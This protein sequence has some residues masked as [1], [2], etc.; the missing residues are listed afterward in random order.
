[1]RAILPLLLLLL[2]P[3]LSR[4][5]LTVQNLAEFREGGT[6]GADAALLPDFYDQVRVEAAYGNL[7]TWMRVQTYGT[8]RESGTYAQW[9]QFGIAYSPGRFRL[10]AGHLGTKLGEGV[11]V[12]SFDIRESILEHELYRTRQANYRDVLGFQGG[13]QGRIWDLTYLHGRSLDP[14]VSPLQPLSLRRPVGMDALESGWSVRSQRIGLVLLRRATEPSPRY[15]YSLLFSGSILG[16]MK[17]GMEYSQEA[18]AG[19][20]LPFAGEDVRHAWYGHLR[21]SLGTF[22]LRGNGREK[23]ISTRKRGSRA[24]LRCCGKGTPGIC[25]GDSPMSRRPGMNR[26]PC[27]RQ[28]KISGTAGF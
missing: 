21:L 2:L 8:A 5:Q 27:G 7:E 18:T 10:H 24:C 15:D 9:S 25:S 13:Y 17:Y 22:R 11:L 3:A 14:A 16:L 4:A 28:R 1:M 12:R 6:P 20:L 23:P 26:G 19:H